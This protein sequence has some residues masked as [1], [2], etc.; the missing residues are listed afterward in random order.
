MSDNII[1]FP[2]ESDEPPVDYEAIERQEMDR[3]IDLLLDAVHNILDECE[4]LDFEEILAA[5]A[6]VTSRVRWAAAA[7]AARI[8][9]NG[10]LMQHLDREGKPVPDTLPDNGGF[11]EIVE[12]AL[13]RR[14]H[15]D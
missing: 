10:E 15:D 7:N 3:A 9:A 8:R 2:C 12:Q 13:S 1:Q 14:R 6:H 5:L 4:F 11:G